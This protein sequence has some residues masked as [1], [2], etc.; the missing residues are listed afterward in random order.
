MY[1]IRYVMG[2]IFSIAESTVIGKF[3]IRY[4]V[5]IDES[6][7]RFMYD[8]MLSVY[9]IS[10]PETDLFSCTNQMCDHI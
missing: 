2:L 9:F 4:E 5:F 7:V 10:L 8:A 1:E 3:N 6:I